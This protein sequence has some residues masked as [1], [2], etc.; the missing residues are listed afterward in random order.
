[1]A[2]AK[3]IRSTAT[4]K[5]S[6]TEEKVASTALVMTMANSSNT[7]NTG[8]FTMEN[9]AVLMTTTNTTTTTEVSGPCKSPFIR[10]YE[11]KRSETEAAIPGALFLENLRTVQERWGILSKEVQSNWAECEHETELDHVE[12][13]LLWRSALLLTFNTLIRSYVVV[14]LY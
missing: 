12:G 14:I 3:S 10:F 2:S 6:K 4:K 1:M 11:S 13:K 8:L 5:K 9:A 7:T